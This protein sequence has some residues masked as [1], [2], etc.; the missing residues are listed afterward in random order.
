MWWCGNAGNRSHP[1]GQKAPNPWG[2]HDVHGNVWEWVADR[3]APYPTS[4]VTDPT[5]APSGGVVGRGGSWN[6]E[7][8]WCRSATREA[9]PSGQA[10]HVVGFRLA[11]TP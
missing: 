4:A 7:A 1:V 6:D 11:R 9:A 5:G 2:L 10:Y 3:Y 8:A